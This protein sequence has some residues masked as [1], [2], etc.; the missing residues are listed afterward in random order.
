MKRLIYAV[1]VVALTACTKDLTT[2]IAVDG[3]AEAASSSK[4]LFSADNAARGQMIVRF[5]GEADEVLSRVATRAGATRTGVEGVDAVLTRVGGT[6]V[7]PLF[8]ITEKNEAR[9][10]AAGMHLWYVL[11]FDESADLDEVAASL[12]EVAEVNTVQYNQYIKRIYNKEQLTGNQDDAPATRASGSTNIPFNDTRAN[13]LWSYSNLGSKSVAPRYA[14][15]GADVNVVPAWELCTGDPSIIVAVLDEGVMY[16]HEDLADNMWVNTAEKN[17]TTGVDDDKNGYIDDIYGYNFVRNKPEITWESS[18]DTGHG[19]HVAGTIAAVSNNGKGICGIAGG[20]SK[21]GIK[22]VSIMGLQLYAGDATS[23]LE[24]TARAIQYAADNGA[25][26]IQCSWGYAGGTFRDDAQFNRSAGAEKTALDYFIANGG[27]EGVITG[28]T[29]IFAAGNETYPIA[30]YPGAYEPCI[31]VASFSCNYKP[32]YY[33]CYKQ[34]VDISAPGG[35]TN[36]GSEGCILSTVPMMHG[37][38]KNYYA[39]QGTSMAC[40]H[41]SGV[42]ALG[43]SYA[44]KLGKS[45]TASEYRSLLLSSVNANFLDYYTGSFTF[46]DEKY[47]AI[48]INYPDYKT[49]MGSGYIDAYKTLLQVEG[50]P[51]VT[52]TS[53]QE[54][55]IDLKKYF[56]DG[57][58]QLYFKSVTSSQTERMAIELQKSEVVGDKLLIKCNKAGTITFEV[59]ALVGPNTSEDSLSPMPATVV[60]KI[61]VFS[62]TN[63]ASNGGWL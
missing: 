25:A 5:H 45:F 49:A 10:R 14:E 28:G 33:T 60:R 53:G 13:E 48:T 29:A 57:A 51:Y 63:M 27:C 21:S 35:D 41:M 8:I 17:G 12:A 59:T 22:G 30:G 6:A 26:I 4:I 31:S 18:K 37:K 46:Y 7:E 52:V 40:P 9:L 32:A 61:V 1:L 2:E 24:E 15:E 56:G 3:A 50:T 11:H 44:K 58:S 39:M 62:R 47:N 20:D 16:S 34:G 54:A 19:T 55:E 43:L 36:H 23:T 38:G 42:A